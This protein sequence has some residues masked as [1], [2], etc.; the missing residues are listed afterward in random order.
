MLKVDSEEL[1]FIE[2]IMCDFK[3]PWFIAG[4]WA[5]DLGIGKQT[6]EHED[7]DICIFREHTSEVLNYFSDW[8]IKVAIPGE[9]RLEPVVNLEDTKKPRYGL[10]L[11]K[12]SRFIEILLTDKIENQITFR[13]D[14]SITLNYKDFVRTDA[15]GRKLIAPE[16]QLLF[17][18]KEGRGKDQHDFYA[19]LPGMSTEQKNWLHS[20]LI[21]HHPVSPWINDLQFE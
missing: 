2:R 6:R 12:G 19:Y 7:L 14:P 9:N 8:E 5:I 13:R 11:N 20:T 17:K 21:K 1:D 4:G 10:H 16:L 3:F 15:V 18:A